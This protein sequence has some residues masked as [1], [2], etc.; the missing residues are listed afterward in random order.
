MSMKY[1]SSSF[2]VIAGFLL[3]GSSHAFQSPLPQSRQRV[4]SP[5]S[6]LYRTEAFTASHNR[7]TSRLYFFFGGN[8]EVDSKDKE[9]VSFPKLATANTDV[10][11]ESL[12]G[13][14][15]TWS[16]KFEDDRKAMGLTTPVKVT[17]TLEERE[18]DD[19][20]GDV[21]EEAGVR[22][23]FQAT[24]TGY[25]SKE[26]EDASKNGE[27]GGKK[28]KGPPKEGGVEICVQKMTNGEVQLK[29]RRCDTDEDTMVKEMSEEAIISQLKKA[30]DVWKKE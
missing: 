10:K 27:G 29:A 23:I 14:I 26:E 21:A 28:K 3:A 11:F 5:A 25:K 7:D 22:I 9:L 8:Q 6:R 1:S 24:K 13:F 16:Q 2:L 12:S 15:S 18:E 4:L 17:N 20:N 30:V 19:D